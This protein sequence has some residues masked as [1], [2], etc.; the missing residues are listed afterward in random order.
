MLLY[1]LPFILLLVVALFLKK[2][3][4]SKNNAE[5]QQKSAKLKTK[6]KPT[7]K[8]FAVED[9]AARVEPT[10]AP[11]VTAS[12]PLAPE[13][14]RHIE[15]QIRDGNYFAAEAQI[16]QAL[17][18]DQN[19]HELYLLLLNLH[20]LQN[21]EF[22]VNQLFTHLRSLN[23]QD[24]LAQATHIRQQFEADHAAELQAKAEAKAAQLAANSISFDQLQEQITTP[25][26]QAA[27]LEFHT[28]KAVEATP[29]VLVEQPTE[30]AAQALDFPSA[31]TSEL[32][33][34]SSVTQTPA[35]PPTL[36]FDFTVPAA[37][38]PDPASTTAAQP[39]ALDF[40]FS[41]NAEPA[42]A[43]AL[44]FNLNPS[45]E[46]QPT[47]AVERS[48]LDFS[49]DLA[50]PEKTTPDATATP[51]FKLDLPAVESTPAIDAVIPESV[52]PAETAIPE[53]Q[54]EFTL[55][56]PDAP[57]VLEVAQAPVTAVTQEHD[58]LLQLF[59]QLEHTDEISLNFSLAE[60]Y[61]RLGAYAEA[62]S[63]L[64]EQEQHYTDTQREHAE[65][66]LNKIA[67]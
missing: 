20:L 55:A 28:E 61:I 49:F 24:V 57:A 52:P 41:P 27:P 66:L 16:N 51:A 30:H 35:A 50:S 65:N 45:A 2:R 43:P 8:T 60:Q 15:K 31:A 39:T 10:T 19:Q 26:T 47:P 17:N 34:P 3:E 53:A 58:P 62:R 32:N 5:P 48:A 25:H 56:Q 6:A 37:V 22:A 23:L 14:R 36:D 33:Q 46:P 42:P 38:Q 54:F 18:R 7:S 44:D 59:P 12:T 13:L 1:V 29:Q 21:D 4:A 63:L 9:D 11:T 64:A 40:S 67:V